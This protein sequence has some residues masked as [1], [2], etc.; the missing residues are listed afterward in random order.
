MLPQETP[1]CRRAMWR[2]LLCVTMCFGVGAPRAE[3]QMTNV[4]HVEG[5]GEESSAV[6]LKN[7]LDEVAMELAHGV[8]LTDA[9]KHAGFPVVRSLQVHVIGPTDDASIREIIHDRYC[10]NLKEPFTDLGL[11][12]KD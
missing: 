11:F 10:G 9:I 3:A 4:M 8:Q 1:R 12:R 2:M 7:T 6:E 5:C